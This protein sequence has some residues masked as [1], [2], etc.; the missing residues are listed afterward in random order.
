MTVGSMGPDAATVLAE[1]D[2]W[3]RIM[4]LEGEKELAVYL[5]IKSPH[6]Y[7][8]VRPSLEVA[9]DYR[10]RL[11]FLPYNLSYATMGITTSV[12]P[13]MKRRP[14][15]AAADRKA[16]MYYA[17]A[18][19][20]AALQGLPF[21]SPQHLLDTLP[22][23]KALLF[24]KRQGLEVPFLMRVYVLG[25]GSG[26]RDYEVGSHEQLR[27]TLANVGANSD[28][29]EAFM[30]PDGAGDEELASCMARAESTGFTGVPHYVFDDDASGRRL[31]L[32]GREHLALIREKFHAEGL[33]RTPE[34][35]PDFS[36]AWHGAPAQR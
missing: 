18:R 17:A 11:N 3:Q 24:A 7:L 10:V 36:H 30:A 9:R 33:A 29:F 12:E 23:N 22:A 26:W 35:R 2:E 14:P 32:F 15:N 5:D 20:Y 25:W 28:G 21:R 27:G 13:D 19:E 31:G 6:T 34:V 8:A 1:A 16:R 4:A